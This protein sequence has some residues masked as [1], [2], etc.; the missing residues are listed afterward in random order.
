MQAIVVAGRQPLYEM[1]AADLVVKQLDELTFMN[2][3][4]LF[5]GESPI[6][7]HV[8]SHPACCAQP[9][10]IGCFVRYCTPR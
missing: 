3:K 9:R 6:P 4:Q 8:S 1:T 5:R 10:D 2:L 7:T